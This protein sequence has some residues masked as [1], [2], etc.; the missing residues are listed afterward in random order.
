MA[1]QSPEAKWDTHLVRRDALWRGEHLETAVAIRG[2]A[3]RG[4]F[5]HQLSIFKPAICLLLE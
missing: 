5:S 1:V 3:F 4:G 2:G